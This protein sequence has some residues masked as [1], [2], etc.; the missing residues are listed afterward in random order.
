[1]WVVLRPFG[2]GMYRQVGSLFHTRQ[3]ALDQLLKMEKSETKNCIF[4][5]IKSFLLLK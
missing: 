2:K 4:K 1:M 3:Q 5:S